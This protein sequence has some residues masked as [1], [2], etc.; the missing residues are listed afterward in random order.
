MNTLSMDKK[1]AII[2]ALVEGCPV[3]S[4]E[5]LSGVSRPTILK[6]LVEVGAACSEYLSSALVNLPSK[7]IQ[8]DEI[9]SFVYAKQKNVAHPGF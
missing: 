4:T 6:L 3:R 7:R 1:V 5:R 8:V 9:W 2:T